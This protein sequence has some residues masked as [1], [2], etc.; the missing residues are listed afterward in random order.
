MELSPPNQVILELFH[1][2]ISVGRGGEGTGLWF[3][4]LQCQIG[5][6]HSI[7]FFVKC[8][9][10]LA[11]WSQLTTHFNRY[12]PHLNTFHNINILS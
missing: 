12:S 8:I 10:I 4:K 5:Q 11:L 1:Y 2:V 7:V 6:G 9:N 3:K